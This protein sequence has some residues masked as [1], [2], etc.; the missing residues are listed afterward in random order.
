ML[1]RVFSI[2]AREPA[3]LSVR[4]C[5]LALNRT[6]KCPNQERCS[7]S[8]LGSPPTGLSFG[9][10]PKRMPH[11][12]SRSE[13]NVA[14]CPS[15]RLL[16]ASRSL[17]PMLWNTREMFL[18]GNHTSTWHG[19]H[20]QRWHSRRSG[21]RAVVQ[22]GHATGTGVQCI[23]LRIVNA[24]PYLDCPPILTECNWSNHLSSPIS[25]LIYIQRPCAFL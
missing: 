12:D 2:E 14:S 24:G 15:S 22:I 8:L 5:T 20:R 1:L 10:T 16:L 7:R 6:R 4:L 19:C 25:R 18:P 17:T 3:M 9:V 11:S 21:T 13:A 23:V